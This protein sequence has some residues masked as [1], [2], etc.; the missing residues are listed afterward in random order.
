MPHG[1]AAQVISIAELRKP[2]A[3]SGGPFDLGP[4]DAALPPL[5]EEI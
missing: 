4:I 1:L 3:A 2:V 5:I